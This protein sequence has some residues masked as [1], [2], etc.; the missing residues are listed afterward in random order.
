MSKDN[1]KVKSSEVFVIIL[2]IILNSIIFYFTR[3]E[4]LIY[5]VSFVLAIIIILSFYIIRRKV[6]ALMSLAFVCAILSFTSISLVNVLPI[7]DQIDVFVVRTLSLGSNF[8]VGLKDAFKNTSTEIFWINDCSNIQIF[9]LRDL[10]NGSELDY[11]QKLVYDN[12]PLCDYCFYYYII[13]KNDNRF[14]LKDV[15]A[16]I[17]IQDSMFKYEFDKGIEVEETV[18]FFGKSG[19]YVKIPEIKGYE[20]KKLKVYTTGN[21]SLAF[22][23]ID[24]NKYRCNKYY[25]DIR[26]EKKSAWKDLVLAMFI[27]SK[28]EILTI[29]PNKFESSCNYQFN[30]EK[31]KFE[32]IEGDIKY[33]EKK[34]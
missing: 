23:C 32:K 4:K 18:G 13:F 7:H 5:L 3:N 29:T 11:K 22:D 6:E 34:C 9:A 27:N 12:T 30:H 25:F 10:N 24:N 20:E 31:N 14:P 17:I 26:I 16:K 21:Y 28:D 33:Y 8:S 19:L 2:F 15:H 1:K